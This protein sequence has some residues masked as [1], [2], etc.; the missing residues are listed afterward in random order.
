MRQGSRE[1]SGIAHM[2]YAYLVEVW[3]SG[4]T[5]S[6][7]GTFLPEVDVLP[8][9]TG[10]SGVERVLR[11][12]LI[13]VQHRQIS[14]TRYRVVITA[15][16]HKALNGPKDVTVLAAVRLIGRIFLPSIRPFCASDG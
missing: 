13:I 12:L 7:Y 8:R 14:D 5:L 3:R 16:V 9:N 4:L 10:V 6:L 1:G 2:R 11:G 15:P